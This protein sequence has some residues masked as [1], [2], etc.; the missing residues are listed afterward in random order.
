MK[1]FTLLF[2]LLILFVAPVKAAED[3]MAIYQ[4]YQGDSQMALDQPHRGVGELSDWISDVAADALVYVPGK[5]SEKLAALR[6]LFSDNG[7]KA[8]MDFMTAMGFATAIAGQTLSTSTIVNT[9]PLLI[10]Q[11][12]SAG[13]YA[14]AFEVPVVVTMASVGAEPPVSKKVTLRIQF[15]RSAKAG[16]PHGVLIESW[17]EFKEEATPAPEASGQPVTTP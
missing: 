16:G 14:W 17:Q 1:T 5:S 11:G 8:Y 10:G 12:A 2:A 13:R 6:P 4:T 7:Y 15:G 9:A 3:L